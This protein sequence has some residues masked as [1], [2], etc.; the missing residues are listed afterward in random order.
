[1]CLTPTVKLLCRPE[2]ARGDGIA[3]NFEG[4]DQWISRKKESILGVQLF[5]CA[6]AVRF[7]TCRERGRIKGKGSYSLRT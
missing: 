4:L 1:M 3:L 6:I 5:L 7:I 2:T